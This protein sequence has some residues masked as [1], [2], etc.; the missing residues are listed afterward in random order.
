MQS[1]LQDVKY[2]VR[3]ILK[4]PGYS[5]VAILMLALGIGAN[6]AIFSVVHAVLLKS[7]PYPDP[8]RLTILNEYTA[9]K[10][11]ESVSWMDYL[12]WRQQN[13]SF[14]DLA[15]YNYNDFNFTGWGSP[16]VVHGARVTSGFFALTGA[17]ALLG[18]P[19]TAAEDA[20]GANRTVV[21]TYNFWRTRF[22]A[23]ASVLGKPLLLDGQ[24]Y[25]VVGVL[26]PGFHYFIS[27]V[28]LWVPAA[29]SAVK[30]DGWL[31]RG[32]HPG[33]RVL[34]RL[35]PGATMASARSDMNA[36]MD[37]LD[38]QY[39][40]SNGGQLASVKPFYEARFG[41]IRPALLTL[42]AGVL[43]VL[44]IACAN[45][46]NLS[47]ARAAVRQ[48]EFA[49][50]AAMG[51]GRVR[52]IRQLLTESVL[53]SLI[54]GALGLLLGDWS[55]APLLRLAPP[56]IPRL[57]ETHLDLAVFFF[58]LGVAALTGILFGIAPALQT[59]RVDVTS[60]L[61]ESGANAMG[62]V[63][64]QR[65][66]SALLVA[67][68]AI[69]A[70]LVICAALFTRSLLNAVDVNPGF[71]TDHLLGLD[72]TV[73]VYKYDTDAKLRALLN[74]ILDR[75]RS[76]PGVSSASA[77]FCPPINGDCWGSIFIIEGSPVPAIADLPHTVWNVAD[78]EY[79]RTMGVPLLRG[80]WFS[81]TDTADSPSVI[82]IN[83]A[84][85][86]YL[87]PN[88]NPLGRRIKQGYPNSKGP[89]REVIGVVGNLKQ[90]GLDQPEL[91]EI[92]EPESQN[93]MSSF[94]LFVRT[95]T[96]PASMA[97]A[98]E[99]AIRSVDPDQA[100]FNVKPVDQYLADSV[101]SR[102]F[103]TL[104]L[105]IF[106]VLALA[107]AAAGIYGVISYVVSQRTREFGIRLALG[108]Q[109]RDVLGIVLGQGARLAAAGVVIGLALAFALTREI[110]SLLFG[111]GATDP[112][113]FAGVA[114]VLVGVALL[115]CFIPARRA[116]RVDP[117]VA[118][119]YE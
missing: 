68:M 65:L 59:S 106:G 83:Q 43:C 39:P 84:A 31:T 91:P 24:P 69:A 38:R 7:L 17:T 110:A 13:R 4:S 27:P 8:G 98:V 111:V 116:T 62:G 6:T 89:Y 70:V 81:A 55:I 104:L 97:G 87:W 85:A 119:R 67:E 11:D 60:S 117:I 96:D 86:K 103:L 79:F 90:D 19:F 47:L 54:G 114:A 92:F 101:G 75:T 12:D 100:V 33:L 25:T 48:R 10:G 105:G 34:A 56:D 23:D 66:R 53:L 3:L 57:S 107:L 22:G 71:R 102:K 73:P 41:D 82:V 113:T 15:A 72:L 112:W 50:R 52:L 45:V 26:D 18:R 16:E 35:R 115:A 37:R 95:G 20:P 94:T 77:V 36:L 42:F 46:A 40:E 9:T 61:K 78:P 14:T 49:V 51:A 64:R 99:G 28:D 29:L 63:R 80:R 118:L 108:A 1:L 76:L 58:S 88:Q 21:L 44:L 109:T 5:V 2:A 93:P 30:D 32:N 74:G